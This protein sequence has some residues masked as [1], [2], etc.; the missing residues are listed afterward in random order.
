MSRCYLHILLSFSIRKKKLELKNKKTQLPGNRS[1]I[2]LREL[3]PQIPRGS[4]F[5]QKAALSQA[6]V[7][8]SRDG[9][10]VP[11]SYTVQGEKRAQ[12][13]KDS[14]IKISKLKIWWSETGTKPHT[15][16]SL[17]SITTWTMER[18][19]QIHHPWWCALHGSLGITEKCEFCPLDHTMLVV[20]TCIR[21][22]VW[23]V[24]MHT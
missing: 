3:V 7:S 13:G 14:N 12:T 24:S 17:L 5:V 8:L 21:T 2:F 15:M 16:L 20:T 11:D 6:P 19:T 23:W 10:S 18:F 4:S 1:A 9:R 22:W